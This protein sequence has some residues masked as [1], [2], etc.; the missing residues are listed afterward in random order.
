MNQ[1]LT[2]VDRRGTVVLSVAT[3]PGRVVFALEEIPS[4][5]RVEMIL[6][7]EESRKLPFSASSTSMMWPRSC[8][9]GV[10]GC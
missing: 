10:D 7:E 8:V 3:K 4:L 5:N 2:F 9:R 1:P 6:D